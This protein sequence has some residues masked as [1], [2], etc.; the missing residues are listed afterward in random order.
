MSHFNQDLR[1]DRA[2]QKAAVTD[3]QKEQQSAVGV[4]NEDTS[5]ILEMKDGLGELVAASK[6]EG[7]KTQARRQITTPG[8]DFRCS[9]SRRQVPS[10]FAFVSRK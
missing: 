9:A 7:K 10:L 5:F 6:P 4:P 3:M 2:C 8:S 1:R